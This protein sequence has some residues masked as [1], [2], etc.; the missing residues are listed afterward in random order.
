MKKFTR[1]F[2]NLLLSVLSIFFVLIVI[3]ICAQIYINH[4]ASE[5]AFTRYASL[6][7]LQKK[8]GFPSSKSRYTP[9]RYLG[10]YPTPN[11][12]KKKDKHNSLGYKG[13]NIE[14]PKPGEF[15]IVCIGGSTTYTEKIKDYRFSYPYLLEKELHKRGY[16]NVTVINAGASA[17]SSWESLINFEFRVLDLE[18]DMIIVYH[19]INDI[20][21]RLVW[22]PEAYQGDNS[23][24]REANHTGL[25][26]PSILEYSTIL[27]ILMIR[28]GLIKSHSAFSRTIIKEPSTFYADDFNFQKLKNTYP[29]GVFKKVSAEQMLTVNTPK[30]FKRNIENMIVIAKHNNIK[31]VLAT[32]AYSPLFKNKPRVSSREYIFAYSQLNGIL[33][34]IAKEMDVNLFDFA[35]VFPKK[36]CYYLDGR[37]VTKK[38]AKLK[39]KLFADYIVEAKLL[40]GS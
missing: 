7:Q 23:G 36:K 10:Y 29:S 28:T 5:E 34:S 37:H 11:F 38:G 2:Q 12:Q 18:P 9:H 3:E 8:E 20:H 31:T 24:A 25:F 16:K 35:N 6:S 15:R 4:F 27:R 39:A 19:G 21:P 32:F 22:P 17:W 30:Y 40:P 33:K 13:Q 14:K 26:M 1:L